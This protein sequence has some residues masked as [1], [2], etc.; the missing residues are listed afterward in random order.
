MRDQPLGVLARGQ[1]AVHTALLL[2][3]WSDDI[4]VLTDGP[5]DLTEDDRARLAAADI[6]VDERKR[7]RSRLQN[8]N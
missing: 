4:V 2:R 7:G 5:D 6:A 8:G 3:G 1:R